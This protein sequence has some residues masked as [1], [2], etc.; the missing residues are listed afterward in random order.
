M[1]EPMTHVQARYMSGDKV[2]LVPCLTINEVRVD[3]ARRGDKFAP[4]VTV[5]S[6]DYSTVFTDDDAA[7]PSEVAIVLNEE[8]YDDARWYAAVTAHAKAQ[9]VHGVLRAMEKA[10]RLGHGSGAVFCG[11]VLCRL[12]SVTGVID[13]QC[14]SV[15]IE[16]RADVN[17]AGEKKSTPLI[18]SAQSGN[19]EVVKM[20]IAAAANINQGDSLGSTALMSSAE[21]GRAE[22][23]RIL[24]SAAAD[25]NHKGRDKRTA[26]M[27]AAHLGR[28]QIV[29]V[30]LSAAAD[31]NLA[32]EWNQ[33]ALTFSA[34]E[35]HEDNAE[36]SQMLISA[37]ADINRVDA[38]KR[39]ALMLSVESGQTENVQIFTNAQEHTHWFLIEQY[40]TWLCQ[41][42]SVV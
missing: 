24:I 34:D 29:Q 16:C 35:D 37:G 3:I 42:C 22:V 15:L 27:I 41:T 14:V 36:I 38:H 30:L 8:P 20:L 39:T 28:T 5:L 26:L 33:T 10:E 12:V 23:V 25:I 32:D 6:I 7:P 19:A 18:K 31:I 11:K 21:A 9:D 1:S 40:F 2:T 13:A 17:Y 4:D